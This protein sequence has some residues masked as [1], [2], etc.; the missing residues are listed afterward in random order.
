MLFAGASGTGKTM[1]AEV[2]AARARARPLP[3]STWRRSS[4]KYIGETE[5]NLDRIFGAAEGSNAMLFFDEADALFG[6]RSEVKDAHDRYANIEVAYLLQ[7][8]E[9]LRGRRRSSRRTSARTSTR[10]SCAGSTSSID[11]PFPEAAD[12]ERIWRRCLPARRRVADDVDFELPRRAVRARP[13]ASIRNVSLAAA[14]LAAADG[15]RSR[16]ATWCAAWRRVP[17]AR[18]A[19]AG[20]G[21][22]GG[23]R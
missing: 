20:R 7:R 12:R 16:C 5:K 6:K 8:M 2:L 4:S 10:R 13:A 22:R 18:P 21:V 14:F 11:F 23:L 17:Q 9:T 15:G 1:A 3:R 19:D